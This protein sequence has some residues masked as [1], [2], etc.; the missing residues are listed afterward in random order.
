ME[1]QITCL[2]CTNFCRNK[3]TKKLITELNNLKQ[4]GGYAYAIVKCEVLKST[5]KEEETTIK[6][7]EG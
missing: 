2:N 6:I 1:I 4:K 3:N 5:L 7:I